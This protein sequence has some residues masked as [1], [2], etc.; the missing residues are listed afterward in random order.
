MSVSVM[1]SLLTMA[2]N[3]S[4]ITFILN[5]SSPDHSVKQVLL[6][7]P[8]LSLQLV[9]QLLLQQPGQEDQ[10]LLLCFLLLSSCSSSLEKRGC[11]EGRQVMGKAMAIVDKYTWVLNNLCSWVSTISQSQFYKVEKVLISV[12]LDSSSSPLTCMMV[13]DIW[14]FLARYGTSQLCLAHLTLL[15]SILQKL[16]LTTFSNPILFI[17]IL[18]ERLTNFLSPTGKVVK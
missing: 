1:H 16:K 18:M 11:L 4:F 14:C 9:V 6:A 17:T 10:L 12:L 7:K 3:Q 15:S 2:G 8:F 5:F 13:S